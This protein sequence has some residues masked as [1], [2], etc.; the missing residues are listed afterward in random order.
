MG[1]FKHMIIL[2]ELY[3]QSERYFMQPIEGLH[4]YASRPNSGI[5]FV[6]LHIFRPFESYEIPKFW[7]TY[8]FYISPYVHLRKVDLRKVDLGSPG[9]I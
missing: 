6:C 2:Q 1:Q 7:E 9:M 8:Q 3:I 4:K 5:G